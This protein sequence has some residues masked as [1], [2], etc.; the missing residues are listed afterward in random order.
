MT[1]ERSSVD[2]AP[3]GEHAPRSVLFADVCDSSRLYRE[4]GDDSARDVVAV[5]LGLA[6][7]VIETTGGR[8]VD[9]VGDEVFCLLPDADAGLSSAIGVHES[10]AD[11]RDAGALPLGIGFRIGLAY[12]PVGLSAQQV[13]GDTVYVAKR[14]SSE[15]KYEQILLTAETFAALGNPDVDRFRSVGSLRLKGR[16]PELELIEAL[17]GP[18]VTS[19]IPG[20][21]PPLR[22]AEARELVL[23]FRE[24]ALIVSD[25]APFVTLGRGES[26]N[27]IVSDGCVS[28]LHARIELLRGEFVW[29]DQ[30]RNGSVI[31]VVGCRPRTVLRGRAVLES[32]GRIQLGPTADSPLLTFCVRLRDGLH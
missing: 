4:L 28:R 16:V 29:I 9:M 26:C 17:W 6:R 10:V 19:E 25:E 2:D 13:F 31:H 30:S 7:G 12:G 27:M 18:D 20:I 11:A 32:S 22:A 8:V 5:T 14:V 1:T 3:A 21:S 23:L 24:Q 15:A